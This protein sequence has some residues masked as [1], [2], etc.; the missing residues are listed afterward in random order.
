[1]AE[2]NDIDILVVDDEAQIADLIADF[3][4][5][6]GYAVEVAYDGTSALERARR[7]W[8]KLLIT[9]VRMPRIDGYELATRIR[10]TIGDVCA[11]FI[12]ALNQT[13]PPPPFGIILAKPFEFD[14]LLALVQQALQR[15]KG[16]AAIYHGA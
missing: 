15:R 8:P 11:I 6:E 13:L 10:Q 4:R 16:G 1:M 3:L 14:R 7:R 9:D 12:S 5:D 2:D